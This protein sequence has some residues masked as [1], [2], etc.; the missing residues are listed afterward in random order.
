MSASPQNEVVSHHQ[1]EGQPSQPSPTS[2]PAWLQTLL[3]NAKVITAGADALPFPYV[4]GIFGTVVF[5]LE[6]VQDSVK[7]LCGDTVDIITVLQDQISAHG[8]TAALK[9]KTQC[10]ELDMFLQDVL[11]A[12]NQ[13]RMKPQGFG[14][15]F[16][17]KSNATL[18]FSTTSFFENHN[19]ELIRRQSWV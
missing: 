16:I 18:F 7:E 17:K 5:L 19:V 11:E 6:A 10:E 1:Q 9:F 4:K 15:H 13:L 8:D 14:A 2:N 3:F 12:V